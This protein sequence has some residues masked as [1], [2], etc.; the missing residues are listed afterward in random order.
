MAPEIKDFGPYD[1]KVDI[2]S[3]GATFCKL[4]SCEIHFDIIKPERHRQL[5]Y[6]PSLSKEAN[7]FIQGMLGLEPEKRKSADELSMHDFL[8]KD[9][10][11]FSFV[12]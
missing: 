6:F 9:V 3:L 11:N 8:I 10:K 5:K 4:L 7:S 1:E 12:N 2:W